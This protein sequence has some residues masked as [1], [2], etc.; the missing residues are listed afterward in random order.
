MT[1]R[2][3]ELKEAAYLEAEMNREMVESDPYRLKHHI[4]PPVGLLNDPNGF[5]QWKG[6]Y[7]LFYQWMPFKTGH[8]AKFWGH[9]T[10]QDLVNWKHEPIALA[11]SE[12]YEKNG[13]YSGSAV[14]A[15]DKMHLFYTGNVKD[16]NGERETYQCLAVSEDGLHFEKKGVVAELPEGYTAHFRDP[17]VWEHDG[18]WYMVVGA[19]TT[20]LKGRTAIFS[21]EDLMKWTYLGD[22]AGSH[23]EQLGEFGYMWECPDLFHLDGKDILIVSPQGLKPQG[24]LY[25][26]VYQSGYF[27]GE[28]DYESAKLT[29]GDF[30]ELD[31]GFDFYAPQTTEDE[32]GRRLLF[33]WMSVP[34]QAEDKHPT[35]PH[36]WIHTMTFPRK[37]S[38]RGE[39]LVQQPVEELE[40]L[41]K[42]EESVPGIRLQAGEK[43]QTAGTVFELKL[44]NLEVGSGLSVS[45]K[46]NATLHYS[47][48][49]KV[50]TLTRTSYAD[51]Q[52]ESRQCR[53]E[54]LSNI[55]VFIDTSSI[56][57]FI[58]DGEEV[59]TA[60]LFPEPDEKS[61]VVSAEGEAAFDLKKWEL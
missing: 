2:D 45:I 58:N 60:R 52:P 48:E 27:S 46:N 41:R 5:I 49:E 53:L 39:K 43:H 12:W 11:P 29:H 36:K 15:F 40:A 17:K 35:I 8:G 32:K 59:F 18:K 42:T 47:S 33:A 10:S 28:M 7:H 30:A 25:Q 19:Q 16:E 61:I 38:M 4:M 6:V 34:D 23:T 20:E 14:D 24:M 3:A 54:H 13:C 55:H 37:L 50:F 56:E 22:V 31:R 57:V 9:Y 1:K 21:S 26:N 51:G 44:E